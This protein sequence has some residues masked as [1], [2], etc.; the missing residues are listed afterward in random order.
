M[1]NANPVDQ[2]EASRS[3]CR[4]APRAGAI[5]HAPT[6]AGRR[7]IVDVR[8]ATTRL[9][10]AVEGGAGSAWPRCARRARWR[11][12]TCTW[13]AR[14]LNRRRSRRATRQR[15]H[16]GRSTG[17]GLRCSRARNQRSE[18]KPRELAVPRGGGL[19][20]ELLLS[21]Y[22]VLGER[23]RPLFAG[24]D[25]LQDQRGELQTWIRAIGRIIACCCNRDR[26]RQT[27]M[28][29]SDIFPSCRRL[30]HWRLLTCLV[31]RN[32]CGRSRRAKIWD[33]LRKCQPR[34]RERALA[35]SSHRPECGKDRKALCQDGAEDMSASRW[36]LASTALR[37]SVDRCRYHL[38]GSTTRFF[39]DAN[40]CFG[41][42]RPAAG[43][44][45]Q[46]FTTSLNQR[47][48]PSAPKSRP[49]GRPSGSKWTP[50]MPT[51]RGRSRPCPRHRCG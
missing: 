13:H 38:H 15:A 42:R 23:E 45:R 49:T 27:S 12:A 17:S 47:R 48:M 11:G 10:G 46:L 37:Y 22:V 31:R 28:A 32:H 4:L 30:A 7:S 34:E 35:M 18:W 25:R 1:A 21:R 36:S 9:L 44:I 24:S 39:A 19:A 3:M 43:L 16:S 41:T 8:R 50:A 33:R 51:M 40:A 20:E 5:P 26:A 14:L 2:R 29:L 6:R